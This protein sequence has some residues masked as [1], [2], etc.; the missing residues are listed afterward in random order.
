MFDSSDRHERP[1]SNASSPHQATSGT[2][3]EGDEDDGGEGFPV[4]C[5][6]LKSA[7]GWIEATESSVLRST[8]IKSGKCL[9]QFY[10]REEPVTVTPEAPPIAAEILSNIL[11]IN[12]RLSQ[13]YLNSSKAPID[14]FKSPQH[15]WYFVRRLVGLE[16]RWEAAR[17]WKLTDLSLNSASPRKDP[18]LPPRVRSDDDHAYSWDS[19]SGETSIAAE[20]LPILSYLIHN[21]LLTLPIIRDTVSVVAKCAS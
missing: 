2:D 15:A 10:G 16:L 17:A 5:A 19:S 21:F 7:N 3:D 1:S 18:L 14:I 8:K 20:S 4:E 6:S 12:L 13:V 9:F 11:A